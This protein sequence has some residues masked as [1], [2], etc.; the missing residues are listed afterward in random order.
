[1]C[2]RS[3]LAPPQSL[4]TRGS[5]D[6]DMHASSARRRTVITRPRCDLRCDQCSV[7]PRRDFCRRRC[8]CS[9][10]PRA[11]RGGCASASRPRHR[12]PIHALA[13]ARLVARRLL[14][15]PFA[16]P[17]RAAHVPLDPV[18]RHVLLRAE[19]EEDACAQP[20]AR[21]S[22]CGRACTATASPRPTAAER[23]VR[24]P[25]FIGDTSVIVECKN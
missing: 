15:L 6:R 4:N 19:G 12:V 1:M 23:P 18:A 21:T 14:Q 3:H 9:A 2:C 20:V 5:R 24:R 17:L 22:S 16:L 25:F 10:A 11:P 8:P 13:Q 7:A